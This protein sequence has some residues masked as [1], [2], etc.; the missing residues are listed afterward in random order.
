MKECKIDKN[1]VD[2][3]NLEFFSK[4]YPLKLLPFRV[5]NIN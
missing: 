1:S 2:N 5:T 4:L 3:H